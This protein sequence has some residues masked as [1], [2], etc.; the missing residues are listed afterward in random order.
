PV[1]VSIVL[2]VV[3]VLTI[4]A[5]RRRRA[6]RQRDEARL[7]SEPRD[8]DGEG[9]MADA[10]RAWWQAQVREAQKLELLGD[11]ASSVA[12]DLNNLLG[13]I[14]GNAELARSAL[15]RGHSHADNLGA[16]LEASDRASDLVRQIF[17]FSQRSMPTREYVNLSQLLLDLRPLL[18]R[19]VP[20]TVQL[21][22]EGADAAHLLKGDPIQLRQLLLTLASNAVF[23]MRS[24]T[25]GVLTLALS[26]RTVAEP[27]TAPRDLVVLQ[28][29]DTGEGTSEHASKGTGLGMAVVQG[30]VVAHEGRMEARSGPGQGT[31]FEVCFPLAV[32]DGL[33][34]E[35]LAP[36]ADAGL[37]EA[38]G[39]EESHMAVPEV[40]P[41][42]RPVVGATI[43]VVDDE[44]AVAQVLQ[45]VLQHY[46]HVVHLF[47][48]PAEAL[49]FIQQQPLA[50][51]LLI[52]DQTMPGMTGD[53]L[54]E[55]VHA[56][57]GDL[58]VLILTGF[59]HD[60]TPQRIE[61]A[62]PY[63]VLLK[64]VELVELKRR[65][66]EALARPC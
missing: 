27:G 38:A 7:V 30:I 1:G 10:E 8:R 44:P 39:V 2:W 42:E 65:V 53:R 12:H 40:V 48:A 49:Q 26:S 31:T 13:V 20:R 63:A 66:D 18:R 35:G 43:V 17:A 45:R 19:L 24:T 52:T 15:T 21:T 58:P 32:I 41:A 16:I 3:L 61:A 50:A 56:V 55:A 46:G 29:R 54:A 25:N 34:D 6:R 28:V 23:A 5:G 11:V 33:W 14:R 47:N 22:V 60:L 9:R 37:P 62:R 36:T 4:A 59:S 57:R 51:D 64:P